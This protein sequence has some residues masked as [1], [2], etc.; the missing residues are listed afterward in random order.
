MDDV[1]R[2]M[3]GAQE[4]EAVPVSVSRAE[5]ITP[6][7]PSD[8]DGTISSLESGD[9]LTREVLEGAQCG[10]ER[11]CRLCL[12]SQSHRPLI[13]ATIPGGFGRRGRLV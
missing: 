9:R 7:E 3:P 11:A 4:A 10:R 5:S 13:Q 12:M 2:R 1:Y 8:H 6:A